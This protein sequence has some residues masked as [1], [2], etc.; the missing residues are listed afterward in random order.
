MKRYRLHING[1][2][3]DVTVNSAGDG[4]ADV[5]VNGRDYLVRYEDCETATQGTESSAQRTAG[6]SAPMSAGASAPGAGGQ[7]PASPGQP[8][9]REESVQTTAPQA[10]SPAGGDVITSPLSGIIVGVPVKVGD[11]VKEGQEVA[12]LEAMKME[13]SIE[14]TSGGTVTAVHVKEGDTVPEG[15]AIVTIG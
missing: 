10:K 3:F 15:A 6:A 9:P 8:V 11:I 7:A 13:N 2:D 12:V 4:A 14:A 5:S 1:K